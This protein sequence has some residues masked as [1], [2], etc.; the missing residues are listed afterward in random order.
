MNYRIT[1]KYGHYEV[2]IN[3]KFY[4]SADTMHEAIRE[5]QNYARGRSK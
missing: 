3:G 2:H 1:P 4:C 5:I